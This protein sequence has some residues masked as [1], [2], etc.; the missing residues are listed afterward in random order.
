MLI[1]KLNLSV[2]KKSLTLRDEKS[3]IYQDFRILLDNSNFD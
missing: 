2:T 3:N 1:K